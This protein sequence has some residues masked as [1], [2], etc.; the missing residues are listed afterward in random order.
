MIYSIRC[1]FVDLQYMGVVESFLPTLPPYSCMN[2]MNLCRPRK[3]K[4]GSEDLKILLEMAILKWK[5]FEIGMLSHPF[6][7][8]ENHRYRIGAILGT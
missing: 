8:N 4:W 3:N 2:C 6:P 5:I 7:N 1:S